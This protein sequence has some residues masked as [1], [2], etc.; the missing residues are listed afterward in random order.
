MVNKALIAESTL[1]ERYQTT[2]PDVVRKALDLRKREKICYTIQPDGSVILT[3]ASQDESDPALD[4][5]L[6]FL[7]NDIK[8]HPQR[9]KAVTPELAL[10][11]QKL[12]SNTDVDLDAP[13]DE[14]DD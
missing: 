1:T 11:I 7:A 6:N 3:R 12:I 9:L 5:F 14:K 4:S 2:V 10:R 13:L 8:K